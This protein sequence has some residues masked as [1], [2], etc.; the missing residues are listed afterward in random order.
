MPRLLH[1]GVPNSLSDSD[2]YSSSFRF[3]DRQYTRASAPF[4]RSVRIPGLM[5]LLVLCDCRFCM[6]TSE[7]MFR[8]G[9]SDCVMLDALIYKGLFSSSE[10]VDM[11]ITFGAEVSPSCPSCETVMSSLR[12]VLLRSNQT[13]S[14]FKV[15]TNFL[16][17]AIS[18]QL[19]KGSR[20]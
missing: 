17:V 10:P 15:Y 19:L 6:T 14:V 9:R 18:V 8:D 5:F 3:Q 13:K 2:N 1:S 7:S 4:I 20:Y 12:S 11:L 16:T